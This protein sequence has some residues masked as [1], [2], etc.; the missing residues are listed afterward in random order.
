MLHE[1]GQ[2]HLRI[3]QASGQVVDRDVLEVAG[4]VHHPVHGR[5]Q[6]LELLREQ[7]AGVVRHHGDPLG[8]EHQRFDPIELVEAEEASAEVPRPSGSGHG[9]PT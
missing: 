7:G 9:L 4:S 6:A 8:L 5:V 1:R 3:A 2:R